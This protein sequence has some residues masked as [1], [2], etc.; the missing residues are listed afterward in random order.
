M[1]VDF[2]KEMLDHSKMTSFYSDRKKA[3]RALIGE[4]RSNDFRAKI[5]GLILEIAATCKISEESFFHAVH[6]AENALT[7]IY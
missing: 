5:L 6:L 1:S 3:Y 2:Y 4:M 7:K